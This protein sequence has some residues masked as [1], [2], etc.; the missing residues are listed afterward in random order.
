MGAGPLVLVLVGMV[1]PISLVL[2]AVAIDLLTGLW[3]LYQISRDAWLAPPTERRA[4]EVP[5]P[6]LLYHH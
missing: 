2:L 1:I 6:P 5:T 4:A 3:V